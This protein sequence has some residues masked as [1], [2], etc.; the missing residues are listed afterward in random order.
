V[1]VWANVDDGNGRVTSLNYVGDAGVVGVLTVQAASETFTFTHTGAAVDLSRNIP[2][3]RRLFWTAANGFTIDGVGLVA[4]FSWVN[5][6]GV[7]T[8]AQRA[9]FEDAR[10]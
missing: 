7:M 6:D 2:A 8:T 4:R 1:R 10:G 3:G 5:P 9:A